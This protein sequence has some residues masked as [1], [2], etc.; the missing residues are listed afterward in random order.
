MEEIEQKSNGKKIVKELLVD[1]AW[2]LPFLF[3]VRNLFNFNTLL[4]RHHFGF[5]FSYIKNLKPAAES[6]W[7]FHIFTG[8]LSI[9]IIP[10]VVAGIRY[11][12]N[13]LNNKPLITA[14]I[15]SLSSGFY[16]WSM[17]VLARNLLWFIWF[18]GYVSISGKKFGNVLIWDYITI[19]IIFFGLSLYWLFKES[20]SFKAIKHKIPFAVVM[21]TFSTLYI[22]IALP[23]VARHCKFFYQY[24]FKK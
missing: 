17:A 24:Y 10:A 19:S 12:R 9:I 13:N 23:H 11:L 20:K 1:L 5:I 6:H 18:Y 14:V 15:R 4:C 22:T 21:L 2:S 7:E 8:L 16:L 3:W